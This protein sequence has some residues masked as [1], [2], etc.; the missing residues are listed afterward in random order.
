MDRSKKKIRYIIQ[1]FFDKGE[2]SRQLTENV[3]SVY[4][5]DTVTADHA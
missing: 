4:G 1:F 3:N 2:H 5:F